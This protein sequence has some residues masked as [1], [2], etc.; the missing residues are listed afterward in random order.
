MRTR[1]GDIRKSSVFKTETLSRSWL[2]LEFKGMVLSALKDYNSYHSFIS[3]S[4]FKPS[5]TLVPYG[6]PLTPE[7][8]IAFSVSH[9]ISRDL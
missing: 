5:S 1:S 7:K 9:S 4:W 6:L 8:A 3:D 2:R